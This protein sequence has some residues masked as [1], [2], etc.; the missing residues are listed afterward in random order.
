ME[1]ESQRGV[2]QRTAGKHDRDTGQ[3]RFAICQPVMVVNKLHR[4]GSWDA[5][6]VVLPIV[7]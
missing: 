7:R 6:V 5:T 3:R 1:N 4:L 2:L